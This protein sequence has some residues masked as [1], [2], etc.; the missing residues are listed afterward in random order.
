MHLGNSEENHGEENQSQPFG[1]CCPKS[2]KPR[3]SAHRSMAIRSP[4][5]RARSFSECLR[6]DRPDCLLRKNIHTTLAGVRTADARLTQRLLLTLKVTKLFFSQLEAVQLGDCYFRAE[7]GFRLQ[8]QR[9]ATMLFWRMTCISCIPG[10]PQGMASQ[11]LIGVKLPA[12]EWGALVALVYYR[13]RAAE[14][15]H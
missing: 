10:P 6:G 13:K 11:R 5:A 12:P 8:E 3:G 15:G 1:W 9:E 7:H 4:G 2:G 14:S